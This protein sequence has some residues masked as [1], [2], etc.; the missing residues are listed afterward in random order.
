MV[1]FTLFSGVALRT[2]VKILEH[3]E[4]APEGILRSVGMVRIELRP[5]TGL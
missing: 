1:I 4:N 3:A 5:P 2:L